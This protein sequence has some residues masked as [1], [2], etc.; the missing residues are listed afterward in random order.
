MSKRTRKKQ[1]KTANNLT[2]SA[3]EK[4]PKVGSIVEQKNA[5]IQKLN[6]NY[7]N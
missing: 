6:N 7:K 4:A 2:L 1:T 3:Q 5:I